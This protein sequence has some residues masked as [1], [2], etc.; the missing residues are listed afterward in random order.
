[1]KKTMLSM[2]CAMAAFTGV[3]SAQVSLGAQAGAAAHVDTKPVVQGVQR[4]SD[5]VTNTSQRTV[6]RSTR[7]VDRGT[8]SA[9]RHADNASQE[10]VDASVQ[11]SAGVNDRSARHGGR[12][13][14]GTNAD[15][16]TSGATHRATG[17]ADHAE[18]A[19][20]GTV[21][22]LDQRAVET[23]NSAVGNTTDHTRASVNASGSAATN[24]KADDRGH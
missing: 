2:M 17:S 22:N 6:D 23:T 24:V 4:T 9:S 8:R 15:L 5:D 11:T 10:H 18:H 12:V 13:S 3:A 21:R 20:T 14:A 16:D 19:T 1:M 7:A